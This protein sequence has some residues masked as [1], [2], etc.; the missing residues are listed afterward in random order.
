MEKHLGLRMDGISVRK[1]FPLGSLVLGPRDRVTTQN[2]DM[3]ERATLIHIHG[4]LCLSSTTNNVSLLP[5]CSSSLKL[6][7]L[8]ICVTPQTTPSHPPKLRCTTTSPS[9]SAL[10]PQKTLKLHHRGLTGNPDTSHC[11]GG[12]GGLGGF[13]TGVVMLF[14]EGDRRTRWPQPS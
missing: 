13:A 10:H 6:R 8:S 1:P 3:K 4:A 2:A 7:A 14:R 9:S 12:R 5:L 11:W